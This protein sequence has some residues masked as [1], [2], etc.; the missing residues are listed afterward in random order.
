MHW[1]AEYQKPNSSR[2]FLPRGSV[3]RLPDVRPRASTKMLGATT[4]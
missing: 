3:L 4:R 2:S 1:A